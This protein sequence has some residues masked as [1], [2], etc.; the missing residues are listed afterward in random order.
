MQFARKLAVTVDGEEKTYWTTALTVDEALEDLDI[1]ADGAW[2]SASRS[3]RL[4][5]SGLELELFTPKDVT[6]LADGKTARRHLDLPRRRRPAR[7]AGHR[8]R[9][10]RHHQG[11][12][13]STAGRR[14]RRRRRPVPSTASPRPSP[15][16]RRCRRRRP[17]RCTWARRRSSR[18]APPAPPSRCG[19]SPRRRR[20]SP[21]ARS[22][23]TQTVAPKP[24]VVQVGTK[25][26]PAR[27]P[28]PSDPGSPAVPTGSVWDRLAQC[29]SGGN[30]AIN[31]GNG[32]YG[33]LQFNLGTWQSYGGTGYPHQN[34][35]ETQIAVA[36][37]LHAARG[38]QPVAGLRRQ[39]RPALS[40]HTT[41]DGL[42]GPGDIRD[43]AG[44]LGVRPTKTLGQNFVVDANTVRSIVRRSG[45][46]PDDVVVEVGPGLGSLTL[47]L[48]EVAASVVAVEID[49][50]LAAALPDH[51]AHPPA[52]PGRRPHRRGRRRARAS[53]SCPARRR[54]RWWPTCPTTSPSR[55]CC[56]SSSGSRRCA[57]RW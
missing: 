19:A 25:P 2:M 21:A 40:E 37:R 35:R 57:R 29:E 20:R 50:V 49:P 54:P 32:Y 24:K 11:P 9:R 31:T 10:R 17:T 27:R 53:P 7:R 46:G 44:R 3:S 43:L 13:S 47:G 1:R 48:L 28:R 41:P 22:S 34:S 5:R 18:R 52:G 12:G 6:V 33:G 39:A 30:W 38:L 4:G 16:R 15:C 56:R 55:C 26:K 23:S 51:G 36:T 8:A 45:V 14:P 42:L